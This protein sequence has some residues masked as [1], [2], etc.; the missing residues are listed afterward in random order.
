MWMLK[1]FRIRVKFIR[2]RK[3]SVSI[4][5]E[6]WCLIKLLIECVVNIIMFM[7]IIMVVII[8]NR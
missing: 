6:G 5:I 7:V 1:F 3:E 8:I 4:F 2:I